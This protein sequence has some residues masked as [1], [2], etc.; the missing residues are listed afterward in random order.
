MNYGQGFAIMASVIFI[1][2]LLWVSWQDYKEMMVVRYSH[3]LGL[4]AV[5]MLA[6]IQRSTIAEHPLEYLLGLGVVFFTQFA[7]YRCHVYGM[8]DV[9]VFFMCGLYFLLQKGA[10]GYMLAYFMVL[11]VSGCLLIG[12]QIARR[13]IKGL[14]LCKPI[15]YIPYICV[16]F[17]LTNVVV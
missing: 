13:N 3:G 5:I 2:Y 4:L 15:A 8:A 11:A 6:I 7:A 12:V 1:G 14:Y 17:V 9:L 10:H 16:A